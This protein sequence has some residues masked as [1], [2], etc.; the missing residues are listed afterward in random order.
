[1]LEQVAR[2]RRVRD[3]ALFVGDADDVVAH[4]FGPGLPSIRDW[5]REHFAFTGYVTGFAPPDEE[6]RQRLRAAFGF[7]PDERVCVVSVGGSGVGR[8]LLRRAVAA[9][10]G[11]A[12]DVPGLRMLVVT[13]PRIDP[14]S[15]DAPAGVEVRGFVPDLHRHLAAADLGIV[16]GGLTTTMELTAARRPFLYFPLKRHFEQRIHVRHRLERYGAGRMME[17]DDASPEVLAEAI[18]KELQRPVDYLPVATDGAARA[19]A[20][21]AELL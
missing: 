21:L 10:P 7:R 15:L 5:T 11:A 3:R 6:E 18:A 17:Y 9:Y 14:T 8:D 20:A 13:G 12:R 2:Y 1:M 19:A 4:P 16:Q